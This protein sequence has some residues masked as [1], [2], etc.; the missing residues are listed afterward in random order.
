MFEREQCVAVGN[1][2]SG[3]AIVATTDGGKSWSYLAMP[4]GVS[5][6]TSVSCGA[7]QC[8][9]VGSGAPGAT[10][11]SGSSN[12]QWVLHSAPKGVTSLSAVGCTAGPGAP[13]CMAVGAS[14]S[15]PAVITSLSGA[16]WAYSAT[17]PGAQALASA[18]CTDASAPSCTTLAKEGNYWVEAGSYVA[19]AGLAGEWHMPQIGG[20]VATGTVVE[21]VSSCI[22]ITGPSCTPS[23]A[24]LVDTVTAVISSIDGEPNTPGPPHES[25]TS[26]YFSSQPSFAQ[27]ASNPGP[28]WYMGLSD[29]GLSANEVLSPV[30]RV[31]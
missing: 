21:G 1:R 25:L 24:D 16:P 28:V 3:A 9:A 22:A 30:E 26:G 23:N 20:T 2:T 19:S 11:L 6:L 7:D 31:Q 8:W 5:S 4:R 13:T 18:A 14:I 29:S 12:G 15:T 17:P 10:L 27:P